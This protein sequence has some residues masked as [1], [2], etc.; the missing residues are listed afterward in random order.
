MLSSPALHGLDRYTPCWIQELVGGRGPVSGAEW[1]YIQLAS[2]HEQCST[3]V[4]TG[5]HPV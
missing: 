2:N 5:A 1:N 3:E 4:S